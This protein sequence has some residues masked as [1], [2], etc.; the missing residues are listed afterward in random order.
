[1][2]VISEKMGASI[3]DRGGQWSGENICK[4][5]ASSNLFIAKL[6]SIYDFSVEIAYVQ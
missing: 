5:D 1:M 6:Y 3:T 4:F 2:N